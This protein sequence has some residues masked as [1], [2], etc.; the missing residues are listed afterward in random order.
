[1]SD[2]FWARVAVDGEH[3]IW[4]GPKTSSGYGICGWRG[5]QG[6][7][8]VAW[9]K[10]V[11]VPVGVLRNTCGR[12]DCVRPSHW[13]DAVAPGSPID[14][15]SAEIRQLFSDGLARNEIAARMGLSRQ[16]VYRHLKGFEVPAPSDGAS[17][18]YRLL[19]DFK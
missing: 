4:T 11:G 14:K 15:R 9:V 5:H 13:R 7:H 1:M 10:H 17:E 8:R 19:A 6:A 2:Q 16:S 18:E 12:L 3:W